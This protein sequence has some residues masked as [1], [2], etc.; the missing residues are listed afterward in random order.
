MPDD[1][2]TPTRTSPDAQRQT[3]AMQI[4]VLQ[5]L[6]LAAAARGEY[7][8]LRQVSRKLATARAALAQLEREA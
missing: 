6:R 4:A 8:T 3:L 5:T 2:P 1:R 7:R